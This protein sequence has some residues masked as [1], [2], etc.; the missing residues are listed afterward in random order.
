MSFDSRK[1]VFNSPAVTAEARQIDR[2]GLPV[3]FSGDVLESAHGFD[4]PSKGVV[5]VS[6]VGE[7]D[8]CAQ[9]SKEFTSGLRFMLITGSEDER[10]RLAGE[11]DT[12]I[13][14][15]VSSPLGLAECPCFRASRVATGIL[16]NLDVGGVDDLETI[17]AMP[18]D[19]NFE[20]LCKDIPLRPAQVETID[21]IPF[22]ETLR[23]LVP[24]ASSD[25][26][27]PDAVE[28]FSNI[29]GFT[30]FFT[31]VRFAF[32]RIKLIFL[33]SGRARPASSRQDISWSIFI[34]ASLCIS[35]T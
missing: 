12:G 15:R 20:Q 16:M 23:E 19:V 34:R 35:Y 24:L 6:L 2:L 18:A 32:E 22:A 8:D 21:A 9:L 10:Q 25:Q 1:K 5:V 14:F 28:S 13:E 7:H 26:N 11:I 33:G 27:P 3:A 29:G 4:V 17:R 30:A 31:N